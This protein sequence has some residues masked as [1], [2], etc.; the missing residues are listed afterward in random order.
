MV[1]WTID[2]TLN[3][4]PHLSIFVSNYGDCYK[5]SLYFIWVLIAL[6][7]IPVTILEQL[8]FYLSHKIVLLISFWKFWMYYNA[9]FIYFCFVV[10]VI[11]SFIYFLGLKSS[12]SKHPFSGNI[13]HVRGKLSFTGKSWLY[14]TT[15]LHWI[16]IIKRNKTTHVILDSGL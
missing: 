12:H 13:Y 1:L 2:K 3:S 6:K 8:M 5:V 16:I 7:R 11:T 4:I 9:L 14:V 10:K 15:L